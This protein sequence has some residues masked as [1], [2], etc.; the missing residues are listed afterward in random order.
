[1]KV[2]ILEDNEN[3][4]NLF[5]R[6]MRMK[7]PDATVYHAETVA[8]AADILE[9]EQPFDYLFLDHDLGGM[10]FVDSSEEETGYHVVQ[11]IVKNGI[12]Y[13]NAIIH[14]ANPVGARRMADDLPGGRLIPFMNLID[15]MINGKGGGQTIDI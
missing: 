10:E 4:M 2:F 13:N 11:F 14:S 12:K 8:Q 7:Y 5:N 1:M 3:R 15:S 6:I 9:K